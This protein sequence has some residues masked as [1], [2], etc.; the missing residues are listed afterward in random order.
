M[1]IIA[2]QG[3]KSSVGFYIGLILGGIN[4]LF[5]STKFLSPDQLGTFRLL[6]E[7]GLILAAFAHLGV[8]YISDKFFYIFKNDTAKHNGF[9]SFLLLFPL[10]G[11]LFTSLTYYFLQERINGYFMQKSPEIL[12][13]LIY[14]LPIGYGWVYFNILESYARCNGRSAIPTFIK[15]VILR[16]LSIT[17]IILLGF[18]IITFDLFLKLNILIILCLNILM[19]AYL[20]HLNKLYITGFT[21]I[22]NRRLILQMSTFGIVVIVGGIGANLILFLDRNII[23]SEIGTAS[24][25]IFAVALYITSVIEIPYKSIRQISGPILS[26]LINTGNLSEV[27]NLYKK[28]ALNL[29]L[30]GGIVFSLIVSNLQPLL[31]CLPRSAIYLQ[32]FWVV[33][34]IGMAKWIDMS[35]GLNVEIIT[36][37][38]YYMVY[39]VLVIIMAILTVF[40][41]LLLIPRYGIV[42]SALATGGITLIS[43]ISRLIYVNQKFNFSPFGTKYL[44][45]VLLIII[46]GSIGY[47]IPHFGNTFFSNFIEIFTRSMIMLV[48]SVYAIVRWNIS[49]DLSQ[50]VNKILAKFRP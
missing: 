34:I 3:I 5:I 32:G 15:E 44:S 11:I 24:V 41:N 19:L 8:P 6:N 35:L 16:L 26:D 29:F 31:E 47:L 25:A 48:L 10:I 33:I 20:F 30:V 43:S 45:I 2:R 37:S 7:N 39:T 36:Y 23:A 13:Y 38:K 50:V 1:G 27:E 46:I 28:S 22:W 18:D 40:A 14:I 4:T 42:G 17:C 49:M 21:A 9:L 12:P